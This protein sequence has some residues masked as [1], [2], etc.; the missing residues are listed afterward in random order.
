M[1]K[2]RMRHI[3]LSIFLFEV[4]DEDVLIVTPGSAYY[5]QRLMFCVQTDTG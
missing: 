3:Y 5:L 4:P 1:G 2:V